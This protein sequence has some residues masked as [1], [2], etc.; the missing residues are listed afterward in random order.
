MR[1]KG[2]ITLLAVAAMLVSASHGAAQTTKA[3]RPKAAAKK[4]ARPQAK[5]ETQKAI[6]PETTV[7]PASEQSKVEPAK[8]DKAAVP[9]EVERITVEELKAKIA[10]NEPVIIIDDR[11]EGSY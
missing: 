11:S 4:K 5:Q 8:D 9:A 3:S 6:D 1:F 2:W 10:A 7:A